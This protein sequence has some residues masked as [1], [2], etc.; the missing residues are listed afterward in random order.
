MIM[1]IHVT[2]SNQAIPQPIVR[3]LMKLMDVKYANVKN[4]KNEQ[5]KF[6]LD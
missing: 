4:L 6:N 1:G 5:I 3:N 2:I